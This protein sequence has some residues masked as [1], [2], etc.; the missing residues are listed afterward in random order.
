MIPPKPKLKGTSKLKKWTCGCTNLRVGIK[1]LMAMCLKC[2]N[3]FEYVA[4]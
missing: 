4:S 2:G 3:R 1:D